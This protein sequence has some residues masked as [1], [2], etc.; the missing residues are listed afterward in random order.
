MAIEEVKQHSTLWGVVK[1][2]LQKAQGEGSKVTNQQ[3][4]DAM[5]AI[6]NQNGYGDDFDQYA[7][8][9][10]KTGNK[11]DIPGLCIEHGEVKIVEDEEVPAVYEADA[12]VVA[13]EVPAEDDSSMV[14]QI[15]M[16][17]FALKGMAKL[18]PVGEDQLP[19]IEQTREIVEKFNRIYGKRL[20]P[21]IYKR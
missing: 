20:W 13:D 2:K 10:F 17:A 6:A 21:E 15:G 12:E 1:N 5:K 3:I 8:D 7:K 18:V 16:T 19:M 9:N 11:I 14:G 4:V